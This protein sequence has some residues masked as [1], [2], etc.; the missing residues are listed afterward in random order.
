MEFCRNQEDKETIDFHFDFS[1]I[2]KF[3]IN[4][5]SQFHY[6]S[7]MRK[8]VIEFLFY[9]QFDLRIDVRYTSIFSVKSSLNESAA[10]ETEILHAY[11]HFARIEIAP[12]NV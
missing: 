10:A 9:F 5:R 3:Q 7:V 4:S 2:Q 11:F 12:L 1:Q 6:A 8:I